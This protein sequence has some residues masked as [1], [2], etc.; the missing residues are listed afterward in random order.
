VGAWVRR[1]AV[2]VSGS[3]QGR[4]RGVGPWGLWGVQGAAPDEQ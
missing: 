2:G 3:H 1:W 4:L